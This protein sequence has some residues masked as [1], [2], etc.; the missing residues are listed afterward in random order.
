MSCIA[1][2]Q[3]PKQCKAIYKVYFKSV[4]IFNAE[5]WTL[6]K[7]NKSKIQ[8][9]MKFMRTVEEKTRRVRIRDEIY[10]IQNLLIELEEQ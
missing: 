4:L 2:T 7:R 9:V 10:G 3:I 5:I 1:Q 6:T 8:E